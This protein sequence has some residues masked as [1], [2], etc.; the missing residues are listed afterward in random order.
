MLTSLGFASAIAR[1]PAALTLLK[2]FGAI[3][4]IYLGIRTLY[5]RSDGNPDHTRDSSSP[6]P[7]SRSFRDGFVIDAVNPKPILFFLAFLPQFVS[8]DS[9]NPTLEVSSLGFLFVVLAGIT[10]TGYAV[11][12][13]VVVE[14]IGRYRSTREW[15]RGISG[16]TYLVLGV[17]A[18]ASTP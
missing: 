16:S 9:G 7:L 3:Y 1:I 10:G 2:T 8:P 5:R 13:G 12:A 6:L 11:C 17:L 14:A 4:L 15:I 18:A